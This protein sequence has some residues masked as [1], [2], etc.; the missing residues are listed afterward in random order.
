[1]YLQK[2]NVSRH[3][4]VCVLSATYSSTGGPGGGEVEGVRAMSSDQQSHSWQRMAA[5]QLARFLVGLR[6]VEDLLLIL[7]FIAVSEEEASCLFGAA[8]GLISL[9]MGL[10]LVAQG[11]LRGMIWGLQERIS[12]VRYGHR[13]CR[14]V[15]R[16][17]LKRLSIIAACDAVASVIGRMFSEVEGR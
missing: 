10:S 11:S 3:S 2:P 9:T 15:L 7:S 13:G 12:L 5:L 1:M 16:V 17:N 6:G 4:R 14:C 8:R